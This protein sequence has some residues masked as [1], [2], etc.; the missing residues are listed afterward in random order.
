LINGGWAV[1][2]FEDG[3]VESDITTLRQASDILVENNLQ[4]FL[5]ALAILLIKHDL[6][7]VLGLRALQTDGFKG[8]VEV[9]YGPVALRFAPEEVSLP[10][11]SSSSR[12]AS[13]TD[14]EAADY[15]LGGRGGR[16]CMVLREALPAR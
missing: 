7:G 3:G 16:L 15:G 14:F 5:D 10:F 6:Q 9:G 1:Y 4:P 11:K 8:W 13:D 12:S 2:E